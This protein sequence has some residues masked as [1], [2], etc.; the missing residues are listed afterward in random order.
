MKARHC[1]NR[2]ML[3]ELRSIRFVCLLCW[4]L[5]T[6]AVISKPQV[7]IYNH[8]VL[9]NAMQV[10]TKSISCSCS[11][12]HHRLA[13]ELRECAKNGTPE[14]TLAI[15]SGMWAG[16]QEPAYALLLG[17]V[18]L[19]KAV[20]CNNGTAL[21]LHMGELTASATYTFTLLIIY[22]KGES[23]W[24]PQC[25]ASTTQSRDLSI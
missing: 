9:R 12:L 19:I 8:S 22:Q 1:D 23:I 20:T 2:L 17:W 4:M 5:S 21:A 6:G 13:K 11:S 15:R 25:A 3:D 14:R 18:V 10:P 24:G 7:S 16:L